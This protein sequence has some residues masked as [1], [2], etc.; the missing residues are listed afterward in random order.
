MS[1]KGDIGQLLT[2][3]TVS[4]DCNSQTPVLLWDSLSVYP[5]VVGMLER[6]NSAL[7]ERI[8]IS[9]QDGMTM[10]AVALPVNS[11]HFQS[12]GWQ[13]MTKHVPC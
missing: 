12:Q 7:K 6:F 3:V 11:Y 13:R 1:I 10:S 8:F 2:T 4:D 5:S 9:P